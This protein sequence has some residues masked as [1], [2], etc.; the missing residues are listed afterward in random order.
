[1]YFKHNKLVGSNTA[2]P[3]FLSR[4]DMI[5]FRALTFMAV[6]SVAVIMYQDPGWIH[7]TF[8]H[9]HYPGHNIDVL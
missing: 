1:M 3:S 5:I 6:T 7:E 9:V 2:T 4:R 8:Y